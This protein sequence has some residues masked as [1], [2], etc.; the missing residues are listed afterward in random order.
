[1]SGTVKVEPDSTP[2]Q[3]QFT[4]L[5]P[6]SHG[7]ASSP[8]T[9]TSPAAKQF[10]FNTMD[11][12]PNSDTLLSF[13]EDFDDV[14]DLPNPPGPSSSVSIEKTIKRR[15]SKGPSFSWFFV[16]Q[17]YSASLRRL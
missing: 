16:L 8:L 1:M 12:W 4:F 5:A 13:N 6:S 14:G 7:S 10:R 2:I 3:A 17:T 15:A 9:T 11:S